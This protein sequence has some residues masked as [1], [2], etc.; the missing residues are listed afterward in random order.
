MRCPYCQKGQSRVVDSRKMR[1]TVRRRRECLRCGQRFTTYERLASGS[2]AVV[3]ND[4]RREP[5]DRDKLYQGIQKACA[6]RPIPQ[7]TIEGLVS[8]IENDLYAQGKAEVDSKTIGEMVMDKLRALDE[9]AYV[10]FA[11]VYRRFEDIDGLSEEIN[12][13]RKWKAD[14]SKAK[15]RRRKKARTA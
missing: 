13:F 11:S 6:K 2:L 9:V 12:E 1:D 7:E 15:R 5:F 14:S 4:D 10:R 3:K 8:Q